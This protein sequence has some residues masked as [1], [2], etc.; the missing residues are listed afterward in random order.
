MTV[1]PARDL[2]HHVAMPVL[3]TTLSH[4]HQVL[5]DVAEMTVHQDLDHSRRHRSAQGV[6]TALLSALLLEGN[7]TILHQDL[8]PDLH[9]QQLK[10]DRMALR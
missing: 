3:Q 10:G 5:F 2:P 8:D 6:A 4:D 1:I 7:E 9:H